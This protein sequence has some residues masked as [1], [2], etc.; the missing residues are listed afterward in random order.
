MNDCHNKPPVRLKWLC[1]TVNK[2]LLKLNQNESILLIT[3]QENLSKR[4]AQHIT[5]LKVNLTSCTSTNE[6]RVWKSYTNQHEMNSNCP[7]LKKKYKY[8][9]RFL[10]ISKNKTFIFKSN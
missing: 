10:S 4:Y 9:E 6:Y 5:S 3:S 1:I 2:N 7:H 8:F